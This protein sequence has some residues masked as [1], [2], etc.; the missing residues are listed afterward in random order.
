MLS[1]VR[2]CRRLPKKGE[3]VRNTTHTNI[4]KLSQHKV[5]DLQEVCILF[6]NLT[7]DWDQCIYTFSIYT[8]TLKNPPLHHWELWGRS[9]ILQYWR[10][11][12]K[13]AQKTK[14]KHR[15]GPQSQRKQWS[16]H[17]QKESLEF[18]FGFETEGNT[19]MELEPSAYKK[20]SSSCH[21]RMCQ[22]RT[23]WLMYH[24]AHGKCTRDKF[25]GVMVW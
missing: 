18:G 16:L 5:S 8:E 10:E 24:S 19:F 3:C 7:L 22:E 2:A 14:T 12:T 1:S 20:Q 17:N 4:T 23:Q 15:A 11:N 21:F 9:C 13:E 6:C 25:R